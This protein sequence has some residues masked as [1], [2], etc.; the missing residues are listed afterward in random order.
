MK[1]DTE[2]PLIGHPFSYSFS[3]NSAKL[4]PAE[5][6]CLGDIIHGRDEIQLPNLEPN[7]PLICSLLKVLLRIARDQNQKKTLTSSEDTKGSDY[8]ST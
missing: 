4:F 8:G 1:A 2:I 5:V 7:E 6:E 3:V